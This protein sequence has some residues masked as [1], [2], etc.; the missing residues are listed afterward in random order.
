MFPSKWNSFALS[1]DCPYIFYAAIEGNFKGI[2]GSCLAD[3]VAEY[4]P[5]SVRFLVF[6]FSEAAAV[7]I[8]EFLQ[9]GS[10]KRKVHV[11]FAE[12]IPIE[13]TVH[14]VSHGKYLALWP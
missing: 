11:V 9:F 2:S 14:S 4:Y 3:H 5:C 12:G 10:D 1:N 13:E 7:E 6:F 8:Y